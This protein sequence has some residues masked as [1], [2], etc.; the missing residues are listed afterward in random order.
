[1]HLDKLSLTNFKNYEDALF[2]FS[3]QVNVIVGPNGSGKT[4]LLDAIYFLALSKSAFQT[5]DALS[6]THDE[7]FF[8]LD[9]IFVKHDRPT[10][11]TISLQKGQRKVI[12][13]DKKPYEKI[14]EHIGRFPV[15]LMA[16]N[17][18]DLVRE[19][20]EDRRQFVDGV[21]SQLDIDYLQD[22]LQYQYVL[23]QRNSLL[24]LF[25]E[26]RAVD[27]DLL[28]TYDQPLLYIGQR[29]FDRRKRFV[30][31]FLPSVQA[32]YTY[33]S[34]GREA[35]DIVY[36]SD[37]NKLGFEDL[38]VQNR[39]RDVAMQRTTMG[40]HRDDFEFLIDGVAL[41]RF[42]S[43]GQQKTFVIALKLAQFDLLLADKQTRPILLL[44]D[45]FDKLDDGRIG[46]LIER[47]S[48]GTFGQL[49][50]TDAR[51]E[52]TQQFLANVPADVR[53]FR[54]EKGV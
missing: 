11:I 31:D 22:Y 8:I 38:F 20:S 15:V 32:H 23:K 10:Q 44:D 26:R 18:T 40:V 39:S 46:K 21:L 14:S 3:H 53:F 49:F 19:H 24:K 7:D 2:T 6:V 34:E 42:G 16:P 47:I 48:D 37:L 52:R 9:G 5:I 43:Q 36:D 13:A 4:N 45:I 27:H 41:K 33:L 25:A 51:P 29:I 54:V 50:I 28:D 17:D 35:V 12:L 30:A 1:M